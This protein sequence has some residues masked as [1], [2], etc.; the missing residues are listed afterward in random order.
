MIPNQCNGINNI[1]FSSSIR[2]VNNEFPLINQKSI[3]AILIIIYF[4]KILQ[5]EKG[6]MIIIVFLGVLK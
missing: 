2:N 5:M 6:F 4:L 3:L 1:F